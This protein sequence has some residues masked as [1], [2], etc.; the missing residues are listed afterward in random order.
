MV[1]YVVPESPAAAAGVQQNDI[2]RMLNDQIL[3]EPGQLAK[4][5]RSFNEGTTINLTLLR[6]GKE[7]KVTPKLTK[8]D[9]PQQHGPFGM[10]MFD[11]EWKFDDGFEKMNMNFRDLD[12]PKVR[13]DV[14]KARHEAERAADEARRAA[15]QIRIFTKDDGTMK[16]TKIDLGKA[17]IV[18]PDGQGE[19]KPKP[20]T[21]KK[22]SPPKMRRAVFSSADRLIQRRSGTK[23]RP[24]SDDAMTN[25]SRKIY[26]QSLRHRTS[27]HCITRA[28]IPRSCKLV[29]LNR[30]V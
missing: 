9:T 11:H 16:A 30:L 1:D 20:L 7:V 19:P 28:M 21:A 23:S 13:D 3:L 8:H 6:K 24:M 10:G 17:Q 22:S 26:L 2:M 4:L 5:V 15:S 18:F 12:L 29:F 14:N 25:W 27:S